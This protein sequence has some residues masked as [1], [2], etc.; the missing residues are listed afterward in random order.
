M[1]KEKNPSIKMSP[2]FF[3]LFTSWKSCMESSS[4][5]RLGQQRLERKSPLNRVGTSSVSGCVVSL[6]C[7]QGPSTL[8]ASRRF[9][10]PLTWTA[11][12][13]SQRTA[14]AAAT[15]RRKSRSRIASQ[16]QAGAGGVGVG[17]LGVRD[18]PGLRAVSESKALLCALLSVCLY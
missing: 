12:M 15:T 1:L 5:L 11:G 9:T 8:Q 4:K 13:S 17:G 2:V 3:T 14:N 16:V 7:L 6:M 18:V 10:T